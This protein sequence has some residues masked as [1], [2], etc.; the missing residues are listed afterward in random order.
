MFVPVRD[1]PGMSK[2]DMVCL[3]THTGARRRDGFPYASPADIGPQSAISERE[4]G[5]AFGKV[6]PDAGDQL[7][8]FSI[9]PGH[10]LPRLPLLAFIALSKLESCDFR[11]SGSFSRWAPDDLSGLSRSRLPAVPRTVTTIFQDIAVPVIPFRPGEILAANL[12]ENMVYMDR[13][14]GYG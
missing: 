6:E 12:S 3:V 4:A 1:F 7:N 11:S 9:A 14:L 2:T 13:A 5:G 10:R 8:T